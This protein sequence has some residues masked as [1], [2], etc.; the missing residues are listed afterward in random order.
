MRSRQVLNNLVLKYQNHYSLRVHKKLST[1]L[2]LAGCRTLSSY[3]SVAPLMELSNGKPELDTDQGSQVFLSF[4]A[5]TNS[6]FP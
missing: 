2:I 6:I 3:Q 5:E 4:K 1:T